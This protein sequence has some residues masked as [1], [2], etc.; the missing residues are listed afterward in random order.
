MRIGVDFDNTIADYDEVFVLAAQR[1]GLLDDGFVGGKQA[2]R[3]ALRA[4]ED[5]EERWMRL[6][7]QVY[8]ALMSQARMIEGFGVFLDRSRAAGVSVCIISH[9]TEHGHFDAARVNLRDAARR[10]MDEQGLFGRYGLA[11]DRVF[12][13]STRSEKIARI[14]STGC[15]HFVDDLEEVFLE[16]EFPPAVERFLLSRG[17]GTLP[18]GPFTPCRNWDEIRHAIFP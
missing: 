2:V 16:A 3:A 8:G 9:K 7:G 17:G 1:D 14:R 6:Q 18:Q 15:T 5:G 13:E 4:V 11:P 12:F 10:W